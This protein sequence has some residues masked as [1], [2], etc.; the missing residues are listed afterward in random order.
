M[1]KNVVIWGS[2]RIGRGF[3]AEIFY[4]SGYTLHFWDK[5]Q[6]IITKLK[7]QGNYTIYKLPNEKEKQK[8]CISGYKAYTAKDKTAFSS[9]MSEIS[10]MVLSVF[11]AAFEEV[12]RE[13]ADVIAMR[14]KQGKTAKLDIILC[15]NMLHA[16]IK[17]EQAI[18]RAAGVDLL[19]Y[20]DQNVGI[21]ES[22][23]LRM[24]V[25]A[26][27]EMLKEDVLVVATN[28]YPTL[29]VNGSAFKGEKPQSEGL[30]YTYEFEA[31]E[32][33]KLYT[34]N[35]L[36]ALLAYTGKYKKYEYVYE[37]FQ[38]DEIMGL[39]YG[40]LNEVSIALQRAYD[41][42][43]RE[44]NSWISECINNM[45]NPLLKDKLTRAG[46]DPI[47]KL[48]AGD[49]LAGPALM[50]KQEGVFPYWITKTIAYAFL[51][52]SAEDK[53]TQSLEVHLKEY[54]IKASVLE[55]CKF[56]KEPELVQ[57]VADRFAEIV[58]D[59]FKGLF[60][61]RVLIDLYRKAWEK[62]FQ[63]EQTVKGC[64]QC[65]ILAIRDVFGIFNNNVFEAATGFSAGMS[66]CGDGACGGYLGGLLSIGLFAK[67][68][69]K[70]IDQKSKAGQYKSFQLGQILHDK[71]ID[72]Y[73]SVC[74][75]DIHECI[76]EKA[77]CLR[78]EDEKQQ[79]EEVGAHKDKCTA[80]VAMSAYMF[81]M[82]LNKDT[83]MTKHIRSK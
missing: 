7:Q 27:P 64:A 22:I 46:A 37:C 28:G 57:L 63:Y 60:E 19:S 71:F 21:C 39:V 62:G 34:Y 73:G 13:L 70:D 10:L 69:I 48:E 30:L 35:M 14:H 49:R 59:P 33:R 74:C 65:T 56:Y 17:L 9:L 44:M 15:A 55:F 50:C 47:R 8:V 36:H 51:Y 29:T 79:F 32:K 75:K 54:G 45:M 20:I 77:Y 52:E 40:S 25:D 67:R 31:W 12:A 41:F 80:V 53:P 6:T 82:M 66:M 78:N 3:A 81:A 61:D 1:N 11:P 26:T 58:G 68:S 4:N 38:D 24:A 76:F 23:V 18:K 83:D 2:G 43:E 42:A 72:C 5:D 16:G